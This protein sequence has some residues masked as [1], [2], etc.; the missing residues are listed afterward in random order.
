MGELLTIKN[1]GGTYFYQLPDVPAKEDILY[2]DLPKKE[3]YWRIPPRKKVAKL[4]EFEKIEYITEERR[5]WVEGVW[6]MNNGVPTY[7]T[8][9][10]YDHLVNMF[11]PEFEGGKA[12][13]YDQQRL[14]FYM[15][16][17]ARKDTN[18]FGILWLKPRRY[19]MTAEEITQATYTSMEDF[20]S[21]VSLMSD[22][23]TKAKTTLLHPIID[24]FVQRPLWCRPVYY[25]PNG[26][27]P[28]TSLEYITDTIDEE[29]DIE[30]GIQSVLG[31]GIWPCLTTPAANDGKKRRYITMD[32][33]WKWKV[34]S[35]EETF[36]INK[37]CVEDGG[38]KG[39]ISV[40][41]TM[42][43]S[44]AY[45]NAIKEGIKM[46][47]ASNPDVRD[48][49][50]RTTS[51]LYRYFVS[52]VHSKALPKEFTDIYGFVD[53]EKATKFILNDLAKFDKT[54]KEYV[55]EQR[56][57]PLKIEDA[58]STAD[59]KA[60]FSRVRINTRLKQLGDLPRHL[61]PYVIGNLI[62]PDVNGK[63]TFEPDPEGK[64]KMALLPYF[65]SLT[66]VN[67]SNR[68]KKLGK[69]YHPPVN[70]EGVVGYD[71]VR[72]ADT[73]SDSISRASIIVKSKFDYFSPDGSYANQYRALYIDR[74]EDP[75]DADME[76]IKACLFFGYMGM[77]E[78]QV[79]RVETT[80]REEGMIAFMMKSADGKRYGTWTDNNKK[81]I[82]A[83]VDMKQA[84]WKMP[85]P[86]VN[87]NNEIVSTPLDYLMMC[88]FEEVLIDSDTVD[89]AKT[90][91]SDVFM[92]EVMCDH[93]L[94]QVKFTNV[95]EV[96]SNVRKQLSRDLTPKR[97]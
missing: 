56:R 59:T 22:E 72:Y 3:Q 84:Y 91:K 28:R 10:H 36:G 92:S 46:W 53:I 65:N 83:G 67:A 81:V 58:L 14:D 26:K 77:T 16:D 57:M 31:G 54:T 97:N 9:M 50:G 27:K 66:N 71:P 11:F 42:G 55:Y 7:I 4:G 48:E 43:D 21:K 32:E 39:K 60:L 35:P 49:N 63:V 79:E 25:H 29:E 2:S 19:G 8:G 13:Y 20:G 33:V 64:W 85:M 51:G 95:T 45:A 23:G 1:D 78:A 88:P 69:D 47:Y 80:M 90:T 5:R 96:Q 24:S 34:A 61:K 38:I 73:T 68:F 89:I 82:K 6:F 87:E 15:R 86:I 94:L 40:L 41:S 62:G 52:A 75:R 37:K 17:L 76:F 44:D 70:P 93:G 30:D 12:R 74:P 18:C